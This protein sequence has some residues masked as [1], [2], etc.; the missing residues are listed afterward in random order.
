M[1][2]YVYDLHKGLRRNV[3]TENIYYLR[4]AL[5]DCVYYIAGLDTSTPYFLIKYVPKN[6]LIC[7]AII[8]ISFKIVIPIRYVYITTVLTSLY[9]FYSINN[10]VC[11]FSFLM[12]PRFHW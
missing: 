6:V 8:L 2:M 3:K 9:I 11:T 4:H 5:Y 12:F 7:Y 10:F 1:V